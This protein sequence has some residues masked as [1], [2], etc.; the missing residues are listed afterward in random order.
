MVIKKQKQSVK[1]Y[2]GSNKY[3]RDKKLLTKIW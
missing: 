2:Q 3:C 1:S